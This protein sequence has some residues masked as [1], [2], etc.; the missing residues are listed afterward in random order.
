MHH[1]H[2]PLLNGFVEVNNAVQK[3][4]YLRAERCH[5]PHRP[6]MGV[7]DGQQA[8]HPARVYERRRHEELEG[9]AE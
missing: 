4:E 6:V 7:D 2:M 1:G 9:H 5:V 3:G 8:V